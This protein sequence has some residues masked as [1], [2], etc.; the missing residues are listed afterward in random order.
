MFPA[1]LV[2]VIPVTRLCSNKHL[3]T[4]MPAQINPNHFCILYTPRCICMGGFLHGVC[5]CLLCVHANHMHIC[6][7]VLPG[8]MFLPFVSISSLPCCCC[9]WCSSSSVKSALQPPS[10]PPPSTVNPSLS[11]PFS[12]SSASPSLRISSFFLFLCCLFYLS[13]PWAPLF[14]KW[15]MLHSL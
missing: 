5:P 15:G 6:V 1:C 11:L 13:L 12:C 2:S 9:C 4:Q 3:I 14:S 8:D 10:K 7:Y